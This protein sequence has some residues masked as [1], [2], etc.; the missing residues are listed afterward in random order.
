MDWMEWFLDLL[1]AGL[2]VAVPA[3][4]C[5]AIGYAVHQRF[6]KGGGTA[7][8]V[9]IGDFGRSPRM[10]YHT[11]SL[12]AVCSKVYVIAVKGRQPCEAVQRCE[13]VDTKYMLDPKRSILS[14]FPARTPW[15]VLALAKVIDQVL[16]LCVLLFWTMPKVDVML[17]QNPP[18]VPI[19]PLAVAACALRGTH[20]IIDWHNLGC[21]ILKMDGRGPVAVR[22]YAAIE[23]GFGGLASSHLCVCRALRSFLESDW[24]VLTHSNSVVMYDHAPSFFSRV[25]PLG[26]HRLFCVPLLSPP[27]TA[28]ARGDTVGGTMLLTGC[29][30][31]FPRIFTE[32]GEFAGHNE[33]VGWKPDRPAILVSATSW[34]IDEDV[35]MLLDALSQLETKLRDGTLDESAYPRHVVVFITGQGGALKEQYDLRIARL[36]AQCERVFV[37]TG[38]LDSFADYASLLGSADLGISLHNSSSGLDLPMKIVDMFGTSLPVLAYHFDTLDELVTKDNGE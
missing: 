7:A 19:L 3:V 29:K 18:A 33:A 9:V 1:S 37:G 16:S 32:V 15:V 22:L 10:Q 8:V 4:T 5:A 13:N 34:T 20:L 25:G 26:A 23:R 30:D 27:R 11:A 35:G 14:L 31:T 17:V 28:H 38:Y 6:Q 2:A 36:N 12:S 24:K 21:T